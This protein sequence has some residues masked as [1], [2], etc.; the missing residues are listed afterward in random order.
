M[1]P[2]SKAI[3]DILKKN[4]FPI[5]EKKYN[6]IGLSDD[7]EEWVTNKEKPQAANSPKIKKPAVKIDSAKPRVEQTPVSVH[8]LTYYSANKELKKKFTVIYLKKL[9]EERNLHKAGTREQLIQ[10]LISYENEQNNDV[11]IKNPEN[12]N[13]LCENKTDPHTLEAFVYFDKYKMLIIPDE[14]YYFVTSKDSIVESYIPKNC[15]DDMSKEKNIDYA[16]SPLERHHMLKAKQL[17]L[18]YVVPDN[19][20]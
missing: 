18:E 13:P 3:G 1:D 20:D 19:I 17:G 7:W 10:T 4:F 11:E 16:I 15:I 5:I 14:D 2:I 9:C 6:I 12:I 8:D